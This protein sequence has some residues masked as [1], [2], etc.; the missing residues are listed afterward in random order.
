MKLRLATLSVVSVLALVVVT[1]ALADPPAPD[2]PA[3]GASFVADNN[4]IT[5]RATVP[6]PT[7]Q[8]SQL[9][10]LVSR[11]NG[12]DANGRLVNWFSAVHGAPTGDGAYQG[13]TNSDYAWP[14]KPGVYFWQAVNPEC[15]LATDC[16]STSVRSFTIGAI[17]ASAVTSPN[18]IETFLNKKP[19]HRTR[20][21]KVKFTFSSNV[22]GAKFQCLF[23]T[24]WEKCKSPHI[25]RHLKAG[26]YEFQVRAVINGI[27]DPDPE[28]WLF[29]V[30][31]R[32]H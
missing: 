10:F 29:R 12:T 6:T 25:F 22:D 16:N 15:A 8:P 31:R 13:V 20:H 2:G 32:H 30:L 14:N 9:E 23:A 26:R 24:G 11:D 21:R 19:R 5:F 17:P 18:Q 4:Q 1:Q 28:T 27:A 7:P 3:D